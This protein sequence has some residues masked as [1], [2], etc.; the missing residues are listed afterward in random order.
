M[1]L[2]FDESSGE[3]KLRMFIQQIVAEKNGFKRD[4]VYFYEREKIFNQ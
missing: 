4:E 2:K 3:K 1:K